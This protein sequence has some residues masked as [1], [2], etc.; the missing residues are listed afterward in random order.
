[1]TEN[2]T[3]PSRV[4]FG[5][6]IPPIKMIEVFSASEWETFIE[7]W[8]DLKKKEYFSIERLGG[9]GD[10]GRDVVAYREDPQINTNYKWDCYQCKHYGNSLTPSDVIIEFGKIIY[11]SYLKKYPVPQKYYFVAPKDCG[12][13][14]SNLLNDPRK[15][16]EEV[17]KQ[18]KS[19][20]EEHITK[21]NTVEL[22]GELLDYFESFDFSIFSKVQRKKVIE[23]HSAHHN[24]LITFGGR[25]PER[26]KL[27]KESIVS[28]EIQQNEIVYVNNLFDAYNSTGIVNINKLEDLT[29]KF[30]NHFTKAR[31]GFHFAEQLRVLYRDSLPQDTFED[32]QED[33]YN[34]ISNTL[35]ENYDDGFKKVKSVEDRSQQ[36]IITSNPLC[37]VSK[38][39]DRIGICHQLSNNGKINWKI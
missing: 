31:L 29:D 38:P 35:D 23:E 36:I 37:E 24:H 17:K 8:L 26:P 18:W 22:T 32:F 25:L 4:T 12:T 10:M 5:R 34:G 39:Q 11:F 33:I 13:S 27:I 20:C 2:Y 3:S 6:A 28:S 30:E 9:A 14:L 19:K 16:K 7:E 1:M 21:V 15:L